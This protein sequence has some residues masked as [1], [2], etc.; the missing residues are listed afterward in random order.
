MKIIKLNATN[1][2]NSF[3]KELGQNS[4]LENFTVVVT[5][6][7]KKGRGQQESKWISEPFKNLTFSVFTNDF[8]LEIRHQKYLN[9]AISLGVF[10]TLAHH[11]IPNLSI[12]WPNDILSANKKICGILI[13][14]NIKGTKI[15]SSIIGIGLNVNQEKFPD[16]IKNVSSLK[17]TSNLEFDLDRLLIEIVENLKKTIHLLSLKEYLKLE[18][19]YLTALYKNKIPSM[20][21]D[22][23][24]ILF[25][26]KI[27]GVSNYGNLQVE[28]EDE[29]TREFGVKEI[30][31]L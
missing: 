20:F 15:N 9:F 28:L 27:I 2:T 19:D 8:D 29:T 1:S 21:K 11:K 3:L 16:T 5:G 26:G 6:E 13:E 24:G 12:K 30:S 18:T 14:N 10:N 25:M 31:F 7:Q 23:D 17:I 22:K 4:A